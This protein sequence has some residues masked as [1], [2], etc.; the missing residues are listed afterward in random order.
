MNSFP[1]KAQG[2]HCPRNVAVTFFSQR[3][4][5]ENGSSLPGDVWGKVSSAGWIE[6]SDSKY[7]VP[8][9]E[10]V[11]KASSAPEAARPPDGSPLTFR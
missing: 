1:L 7:L 10:V 6:E 4:E 11:P 5:K 9:G 8:F 2:G 3:A